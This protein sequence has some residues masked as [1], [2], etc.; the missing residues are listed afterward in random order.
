MNVEKEN[1]TK[2]G[3]SMFEV[4]YITTQSL[5]CFNREYKVMRPSAKI[6][7]GGIG[8]AYEASCWQWR[9]V[10]SLSLSISFSVRD[11]F[12]AEAKPHQT[13]EACRIQQPG[14]RCRSGNKV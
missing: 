12:S 11:L 8:T 7:T 10:P 9:R 2:Y 4:R 5:D 3:V 13:G 6:V 1:G 14:N